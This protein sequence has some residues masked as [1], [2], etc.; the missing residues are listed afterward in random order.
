ME[1]NNNTIRLLALDLDDTVLRSDLT[2]SLRTR[3]A[4]RKVESAGIEVIVASGRIPA[5]MDKFVKQLGLH[6]RN[7]PLICSNGSIIIESMTGKVT[8]EAFIPF[9]SALIVYDL[10]TAEGFSVQ[11]Y[12]GSTLYVSKQNEFTDYDIKLTGLKQI[13]AP[14]F[15]EKLIDGC[16]KL[17]IPGDPMI[18]QPLM[19]LLN[20]YLDKEITLFTSKPYF[21]EILP[22]N[23]NK[24]TAL[25]IVAEKLGISADSVMAVGDSMNDAEMIKWAGIGVAMQNSS[26]SFKQIAD[27]VTERSNDD[28]GVADLIEHIFCNR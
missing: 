11:I 13:V 3:N 4:I 6:K 17:L 12:E 20:S 19:K 24:G 25:A 15:R 26:E 10:V 23:V 14:D 5:S 2:I 16:H 28:D 8:Y 7:R 21:L 27:M 22:P 9:E 1:I 18:L